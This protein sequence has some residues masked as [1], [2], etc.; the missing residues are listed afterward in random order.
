MKKIKSNI[1][2]VRNSSNF[3]HLL[4]ETLRSLMRSRNSSRIEQNDLGEAKFMGVPIQVFGINSLKR[5]Q[6][7]S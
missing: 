2:A 1:R 4:R 3:S 7:V 6:K 5:K